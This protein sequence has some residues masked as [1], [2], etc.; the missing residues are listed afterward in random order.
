MK[1]TSRLSLSFFATG[2]CFAIG[3]LGM[4]VQM[5]AQQ[6]GAATPQPYVYQLSGLVLNKTSNE[7]VPFARLRINSSRRR[8]TCNEEGFFSIPVVRGDTLY[9][10]SIGY[11]ESALVVD[12]FLASYGGDQTISYLY[13]LQYMNEAA[14]ILPGVKILPYN[15]PEELRMAMLNMPLLTN[16]PSAIAR[17][18]VNPQTMN[19]FV[20]NL[21]IDEQERLAA[22]QQR[23]VYFYKQQNTMQTMPLFDPIAVGKLV[24][25]IRERQRAKQNKVFSG[26]PD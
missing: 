7:P 11:T 4:P 26:S 10:N 19:Y 25:N 17:G 9:F 20:N 16:D 23:Y 21:P 5:H 13:A 2:L 24:K 8:T 12:A 14:V 22:N 6:Q 18:N 1:Q 15:T 3:M